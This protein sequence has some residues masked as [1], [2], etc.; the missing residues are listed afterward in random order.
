ME[1]LI[2]SLLRLETIFL[3]GGEDRLFCWALM[4]DVGLQYNETD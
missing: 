1:M 2:L 4:E 3:P